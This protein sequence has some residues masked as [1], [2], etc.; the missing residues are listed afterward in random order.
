MTKPEVS[1]AMVHAAIDAADRASNA[2]A[3][4]PFPSD[5]RADRERVFRAVLEAGLAVLLAEN[6]SL[7][8][9]AVQA[10]AEATR[11]RGLDAVT[12]WSRAVRAEGM[13]YE[14]RARVAE[15]EAAHEAD[16]AHIAGLYAGR[17]R[18]RQRIAYLAGDRQYSRRA[19]AEG[20]QLRARV[21]ELEARPTSNPPVPL[22]PQVE[23]TGA[24]SSSAASSDTPDIV[25]AIYRIRQAVLN[26]NR[27]DPLRIEI[28][29]LLPA[30][31]EVW[32]AIL[33]AADRVADFKGDR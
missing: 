11:L 33:Y 13:A 9:R 14:L 22:E 29:A 1:D 25:D 17:D 3:G 12:E 30:P 26:A 23:A 24:P 15:L 16:G 32:P 31:D 4:G 19:I 2:N 20:H 21:V 28:A 10:E 6:A 27:L 7:Q 5:W 18:M 8:L